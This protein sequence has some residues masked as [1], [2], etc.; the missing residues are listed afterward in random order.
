MSESWRRSLAAHVD[1]ERPSPPLVYPP[2]QLRASGAAHPLHD[3]LPL[4]RATLASI[5]ADAM[6]LMRVTDAEGHV[7]WR[8]GASA[9]L[10]EADRVGLSPG[11]C[12]SE[13]AIGTSAMGTALATDAPVQIHS[14]DHLVRTDHS[15]TCVAAPVHDPDTGAILGA[16]DISGPLHAVHPPLL[17]LVSATAQLAESQLRVRLAIADERL[18]TRN[19]PHLTSLGGAPGALVTSTGR[20]LAAQP[21]GWWPDRVDLREAVDRVVQVHG[22]DMLVEPLAEGCLLRARGP[23]HRAPAPRPATALFLRC[24]TEDTPSVVVG[25]RAVPL[26]LRP[27]EMLTVLALH[28]A[29]LSAE[30]LAHLVY[31]DDGNPTT[32]RGEVRRLRRLLEDGLL[33]TRPYRL[34]ATVGSD[35][36]AVRAALA[37]GRLRTALASCAGP[38]LPRSESPEVRELR[39]ELG[40]ALRRA[41]LED[42]D[43]ALLCDFAAHPLGRTDLEVHDRLVE[44]LPPRDPRLGPLTARRSRLQAD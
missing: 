10:T 37:A 15:W 9:L 42:G 18:R 14:A 35:F 17:Q 33:A 43:T 36:G 26:C 38:L 24:M 25:G 23:V 8:E 39:D 22:C 34:T 32:V 19:M 12:W 13:D 11:T 16:I 44:L 29:G 21:A 20:V 3:L 7:L 41:V 4:L 27:A 31:G 30:R 28:P 6:H 1:P 2:D 40:A 5:A